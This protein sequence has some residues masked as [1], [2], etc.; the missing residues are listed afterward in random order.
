MRRTASTLL[1]LIG[2]AVMPIRPLVAQQEDDPWLRRCED[3]HW[4]NRTE[5]YCE[6]RH[7][8]FKP[9]GGTL[10]FD[11]DQNGG[12]EVHGWDRDS[13]AITA[14]IQASASS[15]EAAQE[16][17]RDIKITIQGSEVRVD[18]P[19]ARGH[20]GWGVILVV[21]V[22]RKSD[23]RAETTNG[24]LSVEQVSGTMALRARNG[25]VSLV[26]IGGDVNARVQNGPLTVELAGREWVGRGLDA[27]SVNGPVQLSIP[28]GYSASLE[29][30]TVNGPSDFQFPITVTLH[31]RRQ[32]R[33]RTTLG[34]GGAPIRVVTTN[35]PLT[36]RK[37]ST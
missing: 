30:G 32:D 20:S 12:L 37:A 3:G 11:P 6:L 23:L 29:T 18:G 2:C 7:L 25:P 26:G 5:P 34:K 31:G 14:R 9:S 27:E 36:I 8:G 4:S 21:M 1:C 17:A 33:I 16:I 10:G 13:V 28:D 15:R 22:P 35:G 19:R 24:P